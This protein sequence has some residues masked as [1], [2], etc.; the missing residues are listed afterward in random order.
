LEYLYKIQTQRYNIFKQK[1]MNKYLVNWK[2]RL[3]GLAA[4]LP[5]AINALLTAYTDG[6][7]TGQSGSQ[8]ATSIGIVLL[9]FYG[10]S[11]DTTGGTVAATPEAAQRIESAKITTANKDGIVK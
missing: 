8:L 2:V 6:T 10:K 5:L 11:H 1:N 4:G 7:F 3:A 9:G